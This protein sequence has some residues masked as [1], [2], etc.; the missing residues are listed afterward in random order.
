MLK[1]GPRNAAAVVMFFSIAACTPTTLSSAS[2][3][4]P[5]AGG[6]AVADAGA[7]CTAENMPVMTTSAGMRFVR[8]PSG[9]FAGLPDWPYQERSV[10]IDGLRQG[11]VDEGPRDGQVI[12]LLHGQPSWSYLYR[13]MIR[14]LTRAGYRVIAMDHLGFGNSD[15]PI[16]L[17]SYS[18]LNHVHR[19]NAFIEALDLQEIT[20][21]AQDW[22]S[23]IGLYAAGENL[24]LFDR[25]I[26][27]NGGLP[28]V[29]SAS[30]LPT[31][32]TASNAMFRQMMTTVPAQQPP[33]F[34]DQGRSLLPSPP[35]GAD[36][37]MFGQ[38]MGFAM[39]DESFRP[40]QMLEALTFDPLTEAE[41]AA[42]D[43]PYPSRLAM[44]G[45]RTFP[46]LRNELVGITE[47]PMNALEAYD[48]P[49]LLLFGGNDPGLAGE[50]DGRPWMTSRIPGARGQPHHT[51]PDAS[52]FLQDDKGPEIAA[53][54]DQFIRANPIR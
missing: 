13:F 1:S 19:L 31:D 25:I 46:S 10:E 29:E 2:W 8:T 38:W 9:C 16:E 5:T 39:T 34:D 52:H 54:V 41:K 40:S 36:G 15:K 42:Y 6:D 45:L 26:I 18:F 14:D 44:A 33:F 7:A 21:F 48:R 17:T 12:L 37:D 11:Y 50:G 4:A 35:E 23:V 32:L 28:V 30:E 3:T 22:G 43:A 53:R 20:L 51:F 49:F 47:Q 27:G 24:N